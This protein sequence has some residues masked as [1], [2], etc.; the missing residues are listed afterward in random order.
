MSKQLGRISG[1]LLSANLFREGTDLRFENQLLYLDVSSKKLSINSTPNNKELFVNDTL[2]T[3]DVIIDS[4]KLSVGTLEVGPNNLIRST[5][6]TVILNG[7]NYVQ[8]HSIKTDNLEITGNSISTYTTD[9]DIEIRPTGILDIYADTN[10]TGDLHS[11]GSITADG[12]IIFG[13]N[14]SDSVTFDADI[15]SDILPNLSGIYSLGEDGKQWN[16]V[17]TK[18]FLGQIIYTNGLFNN[19]LPVE[20]TAK[21]QWF[22]ASLGADTNVGINE[23]SAFAT[24]A[25]ALSVADPGDTVY[26]APGT[27]TEV[28]PLTVPAGVTVKGAGIRSVTVQPTSGTNTNNAFLLNG[29]TAVSDLTVANFY[30]GSAFSFAPGAKVTTRSPYVQNCSVITSSFTSVPPLATPLS[31][32]V[33]N[34]DFTGGVGNNVG[35]VIQLVINQPTGALA[36]Y[37]TSTAQVGDRLTLLGGTAGS[38]SLTLTRTFT[39]S[40][41]GYQCLV[42][43]Y[44]VDGTVNF[45]AITIDA[46]RTTLPAG[47]GALVDGSVV[48]ATSNEASM[49]FHSTTFI[50][51]DVDALTMTNGVRVE[52]LNSFTYF[53]NRSIYATQGTLGFAGLGVKFGA[54]IR[55]IA[56]ASVYGNYGAVADGADTLMYLIQHNFGYVGSGLDSSNDRTLVVQANETVELN[57]GKIYFQSVDQQGN[58]RVGEQFYV[59]FDN[60]TTSIDISSGAINGISSLTIGTAPNQTFIDYSKIDIGDFTLRGNDIL[61]KSQTFNIVSASGE[62]NTESI[63]IAKDLSVGGDVNIGGT[64]TVGNQT[65]DGISITADIDSDIIPKTSKEYNI[66]STDKRWA[67]LYTT[68][69]YVNQVKLSTNQVSILNTDANLVLNATGKVSVPTND[70]EFDQTLRVTG[71]T[72]LTDVGVT[73]DI[74]HTAAYNQT[75]LRDITGN[76]SAT[77]SGKV[78]NITFVNDTIRS[79][80]SLNFALLSGNGKLN[81][82]SNNADISIKNNRIINNKNDPIVFSTNGGYVRF[83][84]TGA[85]AI[86]VGLES[87]RPAAAETGTLRVNSTSGNAEVYTQPTNTWNDVTGL[88]DIATRE[89]VEE[90]GNLW[91]LILG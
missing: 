41:L 34:G 64:I 8:T 80:N 76:A 16:D 53:A 43:P 61:T 81:I 88:G 23:S 47:K 89:V 77:I 62:V 49:L 26:I 29:E 13:S 36:T 3:I 11:T 57:N 67:T 40:G 25:K 82:V 86:P 60:G 45:T 70:V 18:D 66:G 52:W 48:D 83:A 65:S 2:R 74:T 87:E 5:T 46:V 27:Y 71:A 44:F 6:G 68:E 69:S 10:I 24:V 21:N 90:Y 85:M 33:A 14:S 17:R 39:A 20:V 31:Y 51:P 58:Y 32:S 42:T 30:Q 78:S 19:N 50:T 84:G 7:S 79:D 59:D 75:G 35:I 15:N 73:G 55:S 91:I 38:V 56:S 1:P 12:S 4:G 72:N 54:E 63:A 22:V 37:I 9:T 28:F